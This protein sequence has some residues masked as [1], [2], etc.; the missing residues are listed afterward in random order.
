MRIEL[1]SPNVLLNGG[2]EL[3]RVESLKPRAKPRQLARRKLL[4][5]FFDVFGGG[6]LGDIAFAWG[7]KKGGM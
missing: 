3:L 7:A 4:D 2:I 6:H 5:G 1:A